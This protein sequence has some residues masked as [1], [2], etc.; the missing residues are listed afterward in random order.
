M[1]DAAIIAVISASPPQPPGIELETPLSKLASPPRIP[2]SPPA[3]PNALLIAFVT[4]PK[5]PPPPPPPSRVMPRAKGP[6][7]PRGENALIG[8]VDS[9]L[10]LIR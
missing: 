6:R 9:R 7:P 4:P 3:V 8:S 5:T 2:D 10:Y 1:L